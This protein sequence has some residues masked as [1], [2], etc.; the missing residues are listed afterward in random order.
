ML[1]GSVLECGSCGSSVALYSVHCALRTAPA[2]SCKYVRRVRV[3]TSRPCV[4]KRRLY[5]HRV[6]EAP[7]PVRASLRELL[8]LLE[9][10]GGAQRAVPEVRL[11]ARHREDELAVLA[12]DLHELCPRAVAGAA[13]VT[14]IDAQQDLLNGERD[15]GVGVRMQ[16]VHQVLERGAGDPAV[17]A[18]VQ[19][20]KAQP[21]AHTCGGADR[22][23]VSSGSGRGRGLRAR[24]S[25]RKYFR[26]SI[27][28][29]RQK[30]AV[31]LTNSPKSIVPSPSMSKS[32]KI[33]CATRCISAAAHAVPAHKPLSRGSRPASESSS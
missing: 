4:R 8:H 31:D 32:L 19:R 29:N 5:L 3:P 21:A 15:V 22:A 28:S 12:V 16:L 26:R 1:L 2:A 9:P 27:L 30:W 14:V 13:R 7:L 23:R 11:D 24:K 6:I 18:G 20:E 10:V 25:L 33:P 17:L